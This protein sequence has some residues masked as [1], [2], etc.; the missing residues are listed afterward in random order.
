MAAVG[1]KADIYVTCPQSIATF[2]EAAS[3]KAATECTSLCNSAAGS[4]TVGIRLILMSHVLQPYL[5]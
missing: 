1:S 2:S 3:L 4:K 5:F